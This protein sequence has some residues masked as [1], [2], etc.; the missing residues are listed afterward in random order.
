MKSR[1]TQKL[2]VR[3]RVYVLFYT[4]ATIIQRLVR[5]FGQRQ[6]SVYRARQMVNNV[7]VES[8]NVVSCTETITPMSKFYIEIIAFTEIGHAK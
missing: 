7:R 8:V 1:F 3:T 4:S 6:D 2:T 5:F